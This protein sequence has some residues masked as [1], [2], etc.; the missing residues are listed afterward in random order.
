MFW[1]I[2]NLW[3]YIRVMIIFMLMGIKLTQKQ[4]GS[5]AWQINALHN[6]SVGNIVRF[7]INNF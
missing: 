7:V 2:S 1:R 3:R 6:K 5:V 4:K